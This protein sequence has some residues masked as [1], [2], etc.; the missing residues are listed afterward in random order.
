M[1]IKK[2]KNKKIKNNFFFTIG[3]FLWLEYLLP[4]NNKPGVVWGSEQGIGSTISSTVTLEDNWVAD[5]V[6]NINTI[7]DSNY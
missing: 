1:D 2:I 5:N 3:Y 6:Y 4:P 7:V